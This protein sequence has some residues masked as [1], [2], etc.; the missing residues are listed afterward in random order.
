MGKERFYWFS[1]FY[2]TATPFL[3]IAA[4]KTKNFKLLMPVWPLTFSWAY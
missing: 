1:T 2:F 3:I 4:L